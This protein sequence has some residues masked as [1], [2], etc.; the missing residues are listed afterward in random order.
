MALYQFAYHQL[1]KQLE[2]FGDEFLKEIYSFKKKN[3]AYNK[4]LLP[5]YNKY[6]TLKAFIKG[7]NNRP[8]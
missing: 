1:E 4:A 2:S 5:I 6:D 8:I 3:F 7:E